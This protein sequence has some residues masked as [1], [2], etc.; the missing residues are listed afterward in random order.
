MTTSFNANILSTDLIVSCSCPAIV[1]QPRQTNN[2]ITKC[3]FISFLFVLT[4]RRYE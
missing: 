1:M 2:P 3:L 4:M